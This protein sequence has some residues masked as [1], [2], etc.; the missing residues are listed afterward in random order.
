MCFCLA[1][2]GGGVEALAVALLVVV[3]LVVQVCTTLTGRF[4]LIWF[5][6]PA[7]ESRLSFF[8]VR[9]IHTVHYTFL[10][11][12]I[13]AGRTLTAGIVWRG[14][15]DLIRHT[16]RE[17]CLQVLPARPAATAVMMNDTRS[18]VYDDGHLV[19]FDDTLVTVCR[20]LY[21]FCTAVVCSIMVGMY[22]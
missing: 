6:Q 12:S 18:V 20:T 19:R 16:P 2:R 17:G 13:W 14:W 4:G 1:G 7:R 5:T 22:V 11:S 21:L 15:F 9:I 3:V 8:M 10:H